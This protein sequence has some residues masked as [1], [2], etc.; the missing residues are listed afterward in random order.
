MEDYLNS[1]VFAGVSGST[2]EPDTDT[3]AGFD[4]YI[5]WYKALLEVEQAA[6]KML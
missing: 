5:K 6:V 1:S 3:A 2:V 4:S